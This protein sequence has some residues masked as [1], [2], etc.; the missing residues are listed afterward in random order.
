MARRGGLLAAFIVVALIGVPAHGWA[1]N[2]QDLAPHVATVMN[3]E[4]IAS[5]YNQCPADIFEDRANLMTLA[6]GTTTED[7]HTECSKD[8]GDCIDRCITNSAP[9]YCFY[10]ARI[11]QI[12]EDEIG[13]ESSDRL[14]AFACAVGS[15][16]GCTNRAAATRSGR[17]VN[18]DLRALPKA[19]RERCTTRSFIL[20]CDKLDPWGCTMAGESHA[21][22]I[23]T[24]K[25]LPAAQA[26]FEKACGLSHEEFA[27]CR[28]AR[29]MADFY[30]KQ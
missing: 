12:A 11:L 14:F 26:A 27:A 3:N 29:W 23:G 21:D 15:A 1:D 20:A 19:E 30:A 16:A 5:F 9:G 17:A 6:L 7:R 25:D 18:D 13:T 28:S 4:T 22:G 24:P 10:G 8:L 2:T